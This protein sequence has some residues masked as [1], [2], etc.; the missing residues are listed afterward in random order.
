MKCFKYIKTLSLVV[1][2][3]IAITTSNLYTTEVTAQPV[4]TPIQAKVVENGVTSP[5]AIVDNPTIY[6]NQTV[7]MNARFDK[8]AT[9]GLD[10]TPAYRSSEDYISFLIKRDDTIYD[11]P[12]SEMKLFLKREVAEKHIDLKS[13]DE[14]QIKAKVFSTVLGDAWLDVSDIKVIKKAPEKD[15]VK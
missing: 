11:I 8:F 5:L 2:C 12:L 3:A 15:G 6:L 4:A 7:I 10:Y 14:I 9:L 13:G 1:F